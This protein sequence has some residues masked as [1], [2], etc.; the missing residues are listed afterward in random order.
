ML[1]IESALVHASPTGVVGWGVWSTVRTLP[2]GS[3]LRWVNVEL[4]LVSGGAFPLS[5]ALPQLA[6]DG[7]SSFSCLVFLQGT[8]NLFTSWSCWAHSRRATATATSSPVSNIPRNMN[9]SPRLNVRPRWWRTALIS[10][11]QPITVHDVSLVQSHSEPI[12]DSERSSQKQERSRKR[13]EVKNLK[14]MLVAVGLTISADRITAKSAEGSVLLHGPDQVEFATEELQASN[15]TGDLVLLGSTELRS[16]AGSIK[17]EG[18][19]AMVRISSD[20]LLSLTGK[21]MIESKE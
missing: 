8:C 16:S 5:V 14:S 7:V 20:G 2:F 11:K 3:A 6:S 17:V 4:S 19:R 18:E 9:L 1:P 21:V 12:L 15:S 10:E 13:P